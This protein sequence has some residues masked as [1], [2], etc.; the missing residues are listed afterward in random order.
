LIVRGADVNN[1]WGAFAATALIAGQM[2]AGW[3]MPC[4]PSIRTRLKTRRP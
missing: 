4:E 2:P 3:A 1:F